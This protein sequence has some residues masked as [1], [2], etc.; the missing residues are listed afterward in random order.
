VILINANLEDNMGS[1]LEANEN[2]KTVVVDF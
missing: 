2:C 1:A